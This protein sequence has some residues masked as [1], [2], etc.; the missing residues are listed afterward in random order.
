MAPRGGTVVSIGDVGAALEAIAPLCLA[1]SWDNVGWLISSKE[2]SAPASRIGLAIDLTERVLDEAIAA[3]CGVV[4]T[5]HPPIFEPLKRLTPDT[6]AGRVAIRA[7]EAGIAIYS[8][9]TA[10][11]CAPGGVNDWLADGLGSG[12]RR[13]I[14]RPNA[15]MLVGTDSIGD[16]DGA[17]LV[18]QGRFVVLDETTSL[19]TIAKR[20]KRHLRLKSLRIAA[21]PEHEANGVESIAI[22]AGAGGDVVLDSGADLLVTGEM[23]HHKVLAA[24]A[25]GSSVLLSEHSHTERGFLPRLATML[26]DRVAIDTI[27][28]TSDVDPL[29]SI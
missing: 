22:C 19:A 8:P 14:A 20:W 12:H 15:R 6:R 23:S 18:G 17:P 4:V 13:A 11:D 9:H 5:Y 1:E 24:M 25:R 21:T 3:R 27:V 2:H 10:L 7:I 26:R 28:L 29:R 16:V